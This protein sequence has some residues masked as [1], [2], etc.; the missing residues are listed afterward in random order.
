[1]ITTKR[2]LH[3]QRF[4]AAH[5]LGHLL[6]DHEG[7]VDKDILE[8]D[9]FALS[10]NRDLHEIAAEAFAAEFLLPRWLY[11]HHVRNQGWT[12]EHDLMNPDVV[13][14]LSLRMGASYEATCWG[15]LGHQI[16]S[17]AQVNSLR[18]ARVAHLKTKLGGDFRPGSAWSDVWR[19]TAKDSGT[20]LMG[21]PDDLLRIELDVHRTPEAI[22]RD[23]FEKALVTRDIKIVV[24]DDAQVRS[25][26]RSWSIHTPELFELVALIGTDQGIAFHKHGIQ[27]VIGWSCAESFDFSRW[28]TF[29]DPVVRSHFRILAYNPTKTFT[30][31]S[32]IGISRALNIRLRDLLEG[33][34]TETNMSLPFAQIPLDGP[35]DGRKR[36]ALGTR[37][38]MTE[39]VKMFV[40]SFPPHQGPSLRDVARHVG[41]SVGGLSHLIPAQCVQIARQ[42]KLDEAYLRS[43]VSTQL[44]RL[45]LHMIENWDERVDG[46]MSRKAIWRRVRVDTRYPKNLFRAHI[47]K[48]F[49]ILDEDPE[50]LGKIYTLR[51]VR[52][53][54]I[55]RPKSSERMVS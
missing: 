14:Q 20:Q 42:H 44:Y 47:A 19:L 17:Y 48:I 29:A 18:D 36:R 2:G 8:R 1:M 52:R 26:V 12:V 50:G 9:P 32:A 24:I 4:T 10:D 23:A 15:L 6:L 41:A 40:D 51:R 38:K 31:Q 27:R 49:S 33:R 35:K 54:R 53:D 46:P 39:R 13:Y 28:Q 30:L 34:I 55:A 25:L 45:V 37:E 43:N 5:E 21:N 3:I 22:F 16:L 11:R 7:S